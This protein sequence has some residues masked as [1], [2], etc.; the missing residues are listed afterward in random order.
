M[1]NVRPHMDQLKPGHYWKT[2]FYWERGCPEPPADPQLNFEVAT[3]EWLRSAIGRVMEAGTDVSDQYNVPRIG[4]TAAVQEVFD[5]LPEYFNRP[6]NWWLLAR[7]HM[8]EAVGFVLPVLFKE[9][10]FW[11]DSSPQGTV[12]YMGFLPEFRGKVYA[13]ELVHEATRLFVGAGCWRIFCDTGTDNTP[14][15]RTFRQAGYMERK[16]WQRP[17]SE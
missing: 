13:I 10:R 3:D 4:V 6:P 9:A 7:N 1:S 12:L 16:P 14:M 17:L 11:R 5:L 8:N 15:I 2:P